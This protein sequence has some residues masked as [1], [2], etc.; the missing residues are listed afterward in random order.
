MGR[1]QLEDELNETRDLLNSISPS[2][3]LAKWLQHTLYLQNG[4]NHSCHHPP[5]HKIPVEEVKA[6]YKA[7]HN[8]Q[9]KK[10]RMKQMLDGER[11]KECD[12]CWRVEDQGDKFFSDRTYKS[13]TSWAMPH[14]YDVMEKGAD[15]DIEPSYLEISFSNVCNLKCAY[16][17]PD[18]S[19]KWMEEINQYGEYPTHFKHN[20]LEAQVD[21]GR[22]P[23]PKKDPNPYV[24]AFWKWW[25]ELYPNLHT[26]RL[27]GGE[28]LMS[29]DCWQVLEAIRDNPRDDLVLAINTNLD[30]EPK[31]LER[32]VALAKE[33][34]PNIKELQ[35]FTSG[36]ST[37][38]AAEY[39]RFG[40]DYDRWYKNCD[41]VLSELYGEFKLI[42]AFM[43][44]VNILSV[45]TYDKFLKDVIKLRAKYIKHKDDGNVLPCMSNFLRYPNFL[46]VCNLD[47][48]TKAEVEKRIINV[49][50]SY[51]VGNTKDTGFLWLEEINQLE[52]LLAFM[53]D[54]SIGE[55]DMN[56]SDFWKYVD[57]YDKRRN[58][59][60]S[61]TFPELETYYKICKTYDYQG[62]S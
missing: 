12:Y 43:T 25:P 59:D 47:D 52:R 30:V 8:T 51:Q 19:S 29:K 57:E 24:D 28:P 56:R 32:F 27:T 42:F 40:L 41:W 50:E 20:N 17:S 49:A 33:I 34:G 54:D 55:L 38:A 18:L 14:I 21:M 7:L 2:F 26:L 36:E 35:I 1:K 5:T 6:N 53:S 60:F 62:E 13:Q 15:T 48:D 37:G 4:M 58:T 23:I 44:T 10:E 9:H 3:C 16:C 39:T 11:P 45:G 61:K 46:A 31:L 22:M